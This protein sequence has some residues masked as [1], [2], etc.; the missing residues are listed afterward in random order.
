MEY[1]IYINENDNIVPY[2]LVY[3]DNQQIKS[4]HKNINTG[5]DK[6]DCS[7]DYEIWGDC[8]IK[9]TNKKFPDLFVIKKHTPWVNKN[10]L[11]SEE[12]KNIYVNFK[13]AKN[14]AITATTLDEYIFAAFDEGAVKTAKET[15]ADQAAEDA[16]RE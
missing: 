6:L 13:L 10:V 3:K 15:A 11:T 16:A 1:K 2:T 7:R 14:E 4:T 5:K 12:I 8:Y 9:E